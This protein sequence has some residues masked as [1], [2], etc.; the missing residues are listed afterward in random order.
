MRRSLFILLST[1]ILATAQP[2]PLPGTASAKPA[3]K[4][5]ATKPAT[6]AKTTFDQD[7]RTLLAL[8]EVDQ[9]AM[10]MVEQMGML[11]KMGNQKIPD[12]TIIAE[13]K[14]VSTA[15]FITAIVPIYKKHFTQAEVKEMIK[16]YTSP[17]GKKMAQKLPVITQEA[18]A[19]TQGWAEMEAKKMKVA[20]EKKGYAFPTAPA[21]APKK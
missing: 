12:E 18:M 13:M 15:G 3:A 10:A 9:S 7:V 2:M 20:L 11:M 1:T 14:K 4:A 17:I 16:F 5:T 8:T 21:G 6:T 19:G